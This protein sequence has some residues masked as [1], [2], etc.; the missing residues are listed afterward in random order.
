MKFGPVALADAVGTRLAHSVRADRRYPKGHLLTTADVDTLGKH[1]VETVVA[2]RLDA[3]DVEENEAAARIAAAL[4]GRGVRADRASTGRCNLHATSDGLLSVDRSV[5]DR[6]NAIDPAVTLATLA[7]RTVVRAGRMVATVKIIPFAVPEAVVANAARAIEI[8][9]ALVVHPFRPLRA[10]MISTTVPG[11]KPSVAAKTEAVTRE[12]LSALNCELVH[13]VEAA[14]DETVLA[15]ALREARSDLIVVFGAS[16]VSDE[17]D[18][19]PA[20][21]RAAGGTV[22]M[23]GM[24]VDPGN[25]LC[26][27][28]VGDRRVIGAPGC[29]RSLVENGFDWVL[30]RVAA[31]LPVT[32]EWSRGL[33]VGGLL[34]EIESRPQPRESVSEQG[35]PTIVVLA[36]GRSSRMGDANKL[37]LPLEGK[38]VVAHTVDAAREIGRVRVVTGH[39]RAE[40]ETALAGRDVEFVHNPDFA[41]GMS[42]SIRAGL[43]GV[44]GDAMIVLGDM[45]DVTAADLGRLLDAF[46]DAEANRIVAARDPLNGHRGN[47]VLWPARLIPRLRE[48]DGDRGARALLEEAGSDVLLIDIEGASRDLD[49]P[50][51]YRERVAR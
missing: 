35:E 21:I 30:Q 40:V 17:D 43:A 26:F 34:M 25:L 42:S 5:I 32:A 20:A 13:H 50:Q 10:M 48:L 1:G 37:L 49:T 23:V 46:C 47:P 36:A 44:E 27:G 33:G 3:G 31:D 24:P 7:D 6:V 2:V 14:H 19:I 38:P 4:A 45:P 8:A 12:R 39:Q 28:R 18:V 9:D 41:D 22:D 29:A 51:A 15:E 16:A 11:F